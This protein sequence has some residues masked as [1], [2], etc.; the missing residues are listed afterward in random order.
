MY[1]LKC[2]TRFKTVAIAVSAL[3][4]SLGAHA[5]HPNLVITTDD[6]KHMRQAISSNSSGKFATA[7]ELLKAQVDEQIA[8]PITV[9]V[10]KDGGGGYTHERHKKITN[11]CTTLALFIS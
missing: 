4:L 9:P 7:F 11:L 8:H 2:Q 6:V 10:P 1:L 5:A 3:F